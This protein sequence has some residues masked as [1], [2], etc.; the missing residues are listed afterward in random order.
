MA[1]APDHVDDEMHELNHEADYL[2]QTITIDNNGVRTNGN[3]EKRRSVINGNGNIDADAQ[4]QVIES[5]RTQIQDLFSQVSQLNGKLVRSY[6]RVSDLEDELHVASSNLR[7]ATLKVSQLELERS[8][9]ISA[10]STG[11][12]VE[13]DHVT[14]ELNRLMEKATEEA[15]KAG[16]AESARWLLRRIWM[17]ECELF[18]QANRMVAEARFA[19]A[20]SERKVEETEQALKGAEEIVGVLQTQMQ[21]LQAEKEQAA[22]KIHFLNLHSPYAEYLSFIAHLRTI[23]PATQHTP[24]MATLLPQ[25]FLARLIAED[26]DPTIRLDLAPSLNW[27]TRRSVLSAIHSGQLN[28]EPMS[29]GTLLEELSAHTTSGLAPHT[30]VTCALC[31]TNIIEK[32]LHP[33]YLIR[34]WSIPQRQ[35]EAVQ[36]TLRTTVPSLH[37]RLESASSGLPTRTATIYPLC[38]SGGVSL[39]CVRLQSM[40]FIR[41]SVVEK[42][43]EDEPYLPPP[44]TDSLSPSPDGID[45]PSTPAKKAR[46]G[47]G[48]LWGTMSRSLSNSNAPEKPNGAETPKPKEAR[49][50]PP[51]LPHHLATITRTFC[52]SPATSTPSPALPQAQ[53][54]PATSE[55]SVVAPVPV[56]P[57]SHV[58]PPLP[59]RTPVEEKA[60]VTITDNADTAADV[61]SPP[62]EHIDEF[63][64]P[65]EELPG[66][67]PLD[68][69]A[70]ARV[71]LPP[72]APA[73][74]TTAVAASSNPPSRA[75]SPAPGAPTAA[76]HPVPPPLP[77]RAAARARPSSMALNPPITAPPPDE[78]GPDAKTE[79]ASKDTG[80]DEKVEEP[81]LEVKVEE[82]TPEK[83]EVEKEG[84]ETE[85][86][87]ESEVAMEKEAEAAAEG[88]LQNEEP[89]PPAYEATNGHSQAEPELESPVQEVEVVVEKELTAEPTEAEKVAELD[90]RMY[91]RTWRELM[92]LREEM[93]WARVG[94]VR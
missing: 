72:S 13:K 23:R 22:Q 67:P 16:E 7:G 83:A 84:Q 74:P 3:S 69:V 89:A 30:H 82:S 75:A 6:D 38:T 33:R 71:P 36:I 37:I 77:R 8:Q 85:K 40:G 46:M 1:P 12:L 76:G 53:S 19:R 65:V 2:D 20:Q 47:I 79:E 61:L 52:Y 42:I 18:D 93:F 87:K 28:I 80:A 57:P 43:W 5:L 17:T 45:R 31:G 50:M 35:E 48:A 91:E 10:L 81:A 14:T 90:T 55:P 66:P 62:D 39:D 51:P 59:K 64:T 34:P 24:A 92:K 70:A 11:L 4:A 54:T 41:T 78:P 29:T 86:E 9:H 63:T 58:P 21:A 88:E 60:P 32:L 27:L 73:T 26:S 56:H 49:L 25:P 44:A 94:G 15:A 68:I